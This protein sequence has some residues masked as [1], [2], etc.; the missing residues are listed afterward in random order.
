MPLILPQA[1]DDKKDGFAF[2]HTTR[3]KLPE[4]HKRQAICLKDSGK[5]ELD[6]LANTRYTYDSC[7]GFLFVIYKEYSIYGF[8]LRRR[9]FGFG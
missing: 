7:M 6:L 9:K 5:R 1:D 3:A 4:E 2:L 8:R